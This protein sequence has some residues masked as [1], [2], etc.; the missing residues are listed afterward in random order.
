MTGRAAGTRARLQPMSFDAE[1]RPPAP[2]PPTPLLLMPSLMSGRANG[3]RCRQSPCARMAARIGPSAECRLDRFGLPTC[4]CL[5]S[6]NAI[7]AVLRPPAPGRRRLLSVAIALA[8]AAD[9]PASHFVANHSLASVPPYASSVVAGIPRREAEQIETRS[10]RP[11]TSALVEIRANARAGAP[12][13]RPFQDS[14][15]GHGQ[16][17]HLRA[18]RLPDLA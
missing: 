16:R 2:R 11:A 17:D 7:A 13:S 10:R 15:H 14:P 8:P 3:H 5:P 4:A 12:A 18:P 9:D 1:G 6:A